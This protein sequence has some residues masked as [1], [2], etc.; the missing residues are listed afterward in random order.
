MEGLS[1]FIPRSCFR[2][3]LIETYLLDLSLFISFLKVQ[4]SVPVLSV[5]SYHPPQCYRQIELVKPTIYWLNHIVHVPDYKLVQHDVDA[6][7]NISFIPGPLIYNL[8]WT[9]VPSNP[10][11]YVLHEILMK[12]ALILHFKK[13]LNLEYFMSEFD[14]IVNMLHPE[15]EVYRIAWRRLNVWWE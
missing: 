8:F 1:F 7:T 6:H 4:I 12:F 9:L 2:S 13:H 15:D 3:L 10:K 11:H 5:F 14:R